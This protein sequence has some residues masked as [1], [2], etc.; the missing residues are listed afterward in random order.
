MGRCAGFV[1]FIEG[2]LPGESVRCRVRR[3]H[4]GFAEADLIE[5]LRPSADRTIPPCEHYN[6]CGGC[7]LQHLSAAG[8]ARAKGAQ[9]RS[10]LTRIAS[11]VDPPVDET[12][13]APDPWGYRFRIDFE[14]SG[15][16]SALSLGLHRRG[17]ADAIVPIRR[18]HLISDRANRLSGFLASAASRRGLTAWDRRRRS[19]FLR[20]ASI[21][22][23]RGS[24]EMLLTLETGRGE[25]P[26]LRELA[27]DLRREFPRLVGVVRREIDRGGRLVEESILIGRDHLFE[28]VDGDRFKVP[29][30]GFFQPNVNL[31]T[32]LR[33]LTVSA[34][35]PKP[36]EGIL[37]LFCG[38]GFLTRA[39]APRAG[40]VTAVE[41]SRD[42]LA[43]ARLN[44][45]G[46]LEGRVRLLGGDVATVLPD[47]L[48]E[49][50]WDAILVDPPRTGL[51]RG[52]AEQIATA[53]A[54]RLVYVSCDPATLARDLKIV[55]GRGGFR[56]T[57][58]SPVDLFPQT[59]HIECVA[60]LDRIS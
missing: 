9:V 4:R 51:P 20:R 14:W 28:I 21:Q 36:A 46:D 44:L 22:E 8:Q 39:I 26:A 15:S 6:Q 27:E 57:R 56:L 37:E 58:V 12:I 30:G 42:A 2:A 16:G 50:A 23:S 7:D 18:C 45:A 40:S 31:S 49:R 54:D 38:V 53:K 59:H 52:V 43:A 11:I 24:G 41:G 55:M 48:R 13:M 19:G 3:L 17:R 34:L 32:K 47:L 60:S 5:V 10:I 29:A 33:S 25:P 35:A 1:L